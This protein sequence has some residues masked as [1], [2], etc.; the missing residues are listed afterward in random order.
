MVDD[1][2]FGLFICADTNTGKV[3]FEGNAQCSLCHGADGKTLDFGT[4]EN[5]DRKGHSATSDTDTQSYSDDEYY[6]D[7]CP[8]DPNKI[9]PGACGCGQLDSDLDGDGTTEPQ[10][11]MH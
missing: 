4:N 9:Q 5:K 6:L 7:R 2:Y 10:F 3:L 11:S 1:L 8:K